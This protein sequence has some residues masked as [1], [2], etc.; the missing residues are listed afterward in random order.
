MKKILI[1]I[2]AFLLVLVVSG[3]WYWHSK[4]P[5]LNGTLVLTGLQND[6]Q[7]LFDDYGVP[8]I[9]A[10]SESDAY[11]A[12]GYV[13]AQDRLFQMELM[14]RLA[15]GRLAEV[16]GSELTEVDLFFRTLGLQQYAEQSVKTVAQ[17]A[18]NEPY[19][20][21]AQAYLA[22]VNAYIATG[23]KPIEFDLL[24]IPLTPFTLH[25]SQL[26]GGYMAFSFSEA[27]KQ[28]P[29]LDFVTQQLGKPYLDDLVPSWSDAAMQ[30][31]VNSGAQPNPRLLGLNKL[32]HNIAQK[33][34]VFP[35][36]G[37]NAWAIAP[38]H[39]QTGK[40]ILSNDTHIGFGQPS[41]WYEAHLVYPNVNFY[42]SW[43]G[44]VPTAVLGHNPQFAW[45]ITMFEN[46]D[47]DFYAEQQN[48]QNP[49]QVRTA[50]GWA[51]LQQRT[52]TL[53]IKGKPDTTFVVQS[54][55]HGAIISQLP[56]LFDRQNPQE[57][58]AV[59]WS[60]LL[61]PDRSLQA[62]YSLSHSQS[63]AQA[64]PH[65]ALIHGPGLNFM[66]ADSLGNIAW[67]AS[68]KLP[69]RPANTNSMAILDGASGKDDVTAWYDFADNPHLIN[70]PQGFIA[71]AN[72]QPSVAAACGKVAGYYQAEDRIKRITEQLSSHKN[73]TAQQVRQLINDDQSAVYPRLLAQILPLVKADASNS[74]EQ[75]CYEYLQKWDGNH[76]ASAVEPSI[77]YKF[78]YNTYRYGMLDE[79]GEERLSS[80]LSIALAKRSLPVWIQHD[81]SVWWDNRNTPN[82][83]ETRQQILNRAFKDAVA[84]LSQQLG[85]QPEQWRWD[86]IHLLTHHHPLGKQKPLDRLFDVGEF[87]VA[88]GKEV[89]NNL[90][91]EM[92]T[93]G[94]YRVASG[95]ALRRVVD[96]SKPLNATSCIPTGQSG[97]RASPHYADQAQLYAQT[98]ARTEYM[99]RSDIAAHQ[100][101]NLL[102]LA[103]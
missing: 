66:M 54:S 41:V 81:G 85:K 99:Q 68:A 90:D 7:V 30:V 57:L 91:F 50:Q 74:L 16:L 24:G 70:P 89:I 8:H 18:A 78:L 53:H 71:S 86:K 10:Q 52:E 79:W 65:L 22:G 2:A 82:T 102:F 13:H 97:N 60:Y 39:T 55:P 101:A 3:V 43:L 1:G 96:F 26:I 11:R 93:T 56:H 58:I 63:I 37:S 95:A 33:L 12:L 14:R 84:Q 77:F 36:H 31:P 23:K 69:K 48:P 27:F 42:G 103:K 38:S 35:Y 19:Y 17:N 15:A 72:S 28:E 6:T 40:A 98:K 44:G 34:P 46:D 76:A 94:I 32:M 64:T 67:W 83:T 49:Q 21:A 80:F 87:G 4:K 20:Q 29:L 73:W 47:V 62:F 59:W 5:I 92:D 51:N 88:G 100:T 61:F 25:D 9:Y 45:G 75:K